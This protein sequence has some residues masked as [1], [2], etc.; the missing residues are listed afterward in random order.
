[1]RRVQ[2]S[3]IFLVFL[4]LCLFSPPLFVFQQHQLGRKGGLWF[5]F[6]FFFFFGWL[7]SRRDVKQPKSELPR[8]KTET[9][10]GFLG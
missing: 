7:W 6:V 5:G 3:Q 8:M 2:S 9:G 4:S 1:M 10:G